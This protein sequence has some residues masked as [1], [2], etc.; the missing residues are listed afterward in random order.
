M[1]EDFLQYIWANSLFKSNEF[2]T[3]SG[4][5]VQVVNT[6]QVNRDAGPDF[7][8]AKIGIDHLIL[9]GNI[10]I[11][12][13]NSDWFR[14][15]HHNDSAYDNVVL[16]VVREAD[17][18]IYNSKGREIETV[19]LDFVDTL[20]DEY[21][22][23]AG[24]NRQPGCRRGLENMDRS[25]FNLTLQSLAIERLE[26]KCDDIRTILEQTNQ[27]WDECFYRLLCKYW[28]GNVNSE[29]FY[30][31][32]CSIPYRV[33]LKYTDKPQCV[34]ALLLGTS[35]LLNEI[36]EDG[37]VTELCREYRYMQAK[38]KLQGMNPVIWKFMRLRPDAFPTVRLALL[39]SYICCYCHLFSRILEAGS[40]QE[41]MQLLDI[42]AS[43]YWNSHY[44][45]GKVSPV[46][47]KRMGD[48]MKKIILINSIVPFLFIYGRE[49]GEERY[50]EK[51]ISWLEEISA[52]YNYVV[53]AW[54][55]CGFKFDSALQTQAVLQLNKEYCDKHKCLHCR[56]GR[57][58][59]KQSE[60]RK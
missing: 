8:N 46:R 33:L 60:C 27:D 31:L 32:A 40:L 16:S 2:L 26:R 24:N 13:R 30:Q 47:E 56:V 29:A 39:A 7:F 52:E 50:T 38:H 6:G 48:N 36:G 57:Q 49:R 9:A 41:V 5:R 14:H 44:L 34:E 11:H 45:L 17:V 55:E 3:C 18:K 23:M 53:K 28:A 19:I 35:G 22:Y 59:L 10:E 1:N 54:E 43:V 37:Y 21:L 15:G 4:K 51:A 20:Y 42:K 58:V 25:W 12:L